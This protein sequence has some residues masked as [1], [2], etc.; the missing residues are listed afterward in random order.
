MEGEMEEEWTEG[1]ED[2][3]LIQDGWTGRSVARPVGGGRM[4]RHREHGGS[5]HRK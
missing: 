3:P 1:R 5:G 4:G 2:E